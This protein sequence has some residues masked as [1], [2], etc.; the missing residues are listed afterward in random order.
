MCEAPFFLAARSENEMRETAKKRYAAVGTGGRIPMFIDP[1]VRD[2][3]DQNELVGLCDA[4]RQRAIYHQ[5]RLMREYGY[6]EVPVFGADE[7][8]KMLAETRPDT[9]IVCTVDALHH[10]YIV[11]ALRAG[12]DVVTEKPMTTDGE[13]CREIFAAA[14]ET[15]RSVRVTFNVRFGPGPSKLREIVAAKTIGEIKAVN[16]EYQLDT[17][18]GAD[19]FR[20]WHSE[21]NQ[22]GGLLLHKSTHHFDFVNWCIDRVPETVFAWGALN[23][24][25]AENARARGDEK[26][27]G[28]DRYDEKSLANADPFHLS[29][30]EGTARELYLDAEAESGYVRNRNVFRGGIDIEDTLAVLVKYRGGILLNYSLVAFSPL[31]GFRLT[32]TGDRGRIEYSESHT[33]HVILGQ[34]DEELAEQ[35]SEGEG[36]RVSLW[37][38]PHFGRGYEVKIPRLEGSHGG[39]DPL[40]QRE[41]FDA[42]AP[43]DNLGRSAGYQQGA[44]SLLIG[45]AAN[46][47]MESGLPVA[48][49]DLCELPK[50]ARKL[51]ELI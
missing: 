50:N 42:D 34:S 9:V 24:Y 27:T 41:I 32:L 29:I 16:L 4:S 14:Q 2:Y 22:S 51:S 40:L 10:D 3:R 1:L 30:D 8:E 44:A 12:C 45:A 25:G 19:Y 31:E 38:Y 15:G 28:Y 5:Q 21:K 39:G 47:S 36:H 6:S 13:K 35:Q 18:H 11:R 48:I 43:P 17:A 26:L 46:A 37:V 33:S 20:R 23:F 49:D 7:F